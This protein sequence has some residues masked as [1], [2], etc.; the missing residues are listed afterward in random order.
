MVTLTIQ[1]QLFD[2]D[3]VL[4][5]LKTTIKRLSLA[6]LRHLFMILHIYMNKRKQ[7]YHILIT[8]KMYTPARTAPRKPYPHWHKICKTLPLLAQI[9]GANPYPYWHKST[10]M[11]TLCGTTIVKQWLIGA[12]GG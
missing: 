12:I 7:I 1:Y 8:Q 6:C 10:K 11:G 9:L 4:F 2:Y 3:R 5:F